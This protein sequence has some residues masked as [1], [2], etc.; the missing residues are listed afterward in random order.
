MSTSSV[1]PLAGKPAPSSILVNLPRLLT[2]FY[3]RQPDPKIAEQR[4]SFGTSGHRGSSLS[5]SF[6][7]AH[8]AAITQAIAEHRRSERIDGPIFIGIDTHALSEP[9][10]AVAIE[11]LAGNGAAIYIATDPGY[12]P[13]PA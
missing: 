7:E 5:D 3:S 1:S 10:Q 13:T 12:T 8:I 2:T 11:V 6:N 9:A 4:V